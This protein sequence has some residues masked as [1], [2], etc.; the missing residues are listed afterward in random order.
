MAEAA[1][2]RPVEGGPIMQFTRLAW[3]SLAF[4][5]AATRAAGPAS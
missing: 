4:F 3:R 5:A 1:S 2:S